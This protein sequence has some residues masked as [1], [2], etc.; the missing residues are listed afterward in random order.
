[1]SHLFDAL[2]KAEAERSGIDLKIFAA[3]ELLQVAESEAAADREMAV[4]SAEW[5]GESGTETSSF[6]QPALQPLPQ[7]SNRESV[8]P[9]AEL[10]MEEN[11]RDEIMKFM[12]HVFLMPGAEAPRTVALAGTEPQNGCSWICCR[13][14][15]IL[16]SQVKGPIC[17]VDANLRSPGLHQMLGVENHH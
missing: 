6:V 13:A 8:A 12:Q 10:E 3:T 7:E 14:A 2:Q 17:I 1:M 16:A 4:Q 15:A 5:P 9:P 11:Q